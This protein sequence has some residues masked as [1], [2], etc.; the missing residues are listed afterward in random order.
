MIQF[1][2]FF[3]AAV[4]YVYIL[5]SPKSD[6]YYVGHTNDI[7]RRLEEHNHPKEAIKYTSK[8]L[9]WKLKLF[10]LVSENRGDAIKVERFI[11]NQKSKSFLQ[12][13]I[14]EKNNKQ[15][16]DTL[17]DNVLKKGG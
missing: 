6:R 2:S 4:F 11:K 3:F 8:Y 14:S 7:D 5:Y 10:F 9:P 15:Y 13:L 17:I 12:N 16:L 1:I